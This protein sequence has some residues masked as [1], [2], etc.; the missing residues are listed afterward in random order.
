MNDILHFVYNL[1]SSKLLTKTRGRQLLTGIFS[2]IFALLEL[3]CLLAN[4]LSLTHLVLEL[5]YRLTGL[6]YLL[7]DLT[8]FTLQLDQLPLHMVVIL[9]LQ[10]D[11][12][13]QVIEVLHKLRV[14]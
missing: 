3:L 13:L 5:S 2:F 7:L 4:M 12:R 6:H 1:N 14:Y 8:L 9:A 11:R 10:S